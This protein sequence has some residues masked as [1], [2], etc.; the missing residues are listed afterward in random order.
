VLQCVA[1][2]C[3]LISTTDWC[4]AVRCSVMQLRVLTS[5]RGTLM[6]CSALQL[7]IRVPTMAVTPQTSALQC[8]AACCIVFCVL[9]FIVCCMQGLSPSSTSAKGPVPFE[10]ATVV[11]QGDFGLIKQRGLLE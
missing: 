9:C 2:C 3:H 4:A 7:Q 5:K 11:S 6:C 10:R 1:V 8:V